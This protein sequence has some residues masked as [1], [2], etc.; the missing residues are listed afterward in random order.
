MFPPDRLD[1]PAVPWRVVA[2]D[3]QGLLHEPTS[4]SPCHV[5][6]H[7]DAVHHAPAGHLSGKLTAA[8]HGATGDARQGGLGVVGVYGRQRP[9]VSGVESL[10]QVRCLPAAHLAHHDVIRAVTQR[11]A[12]EITDRH[13]S[14]LQPASLEA[15]TI[16]ALNAKLQRVLD[17]DD[18]F[19]IG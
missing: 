15:D 13:R 17:G 6:H 2:F 10:Q 16:G 5:N 9:A 8:L 4:L 19:V 7:S 18:A 12:D 11:V 3:E 14:L 1:E